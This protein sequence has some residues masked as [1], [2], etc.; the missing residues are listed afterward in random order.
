MKFFYILI[1]SN[2]NKINENIFLENLKISNWSL[3]VSKSIYEILEKP[4][5]AEWLEASINSI[6]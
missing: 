2:M 5:W 4:N 3:D 6:E 1:L